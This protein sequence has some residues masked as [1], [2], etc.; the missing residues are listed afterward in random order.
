MAFSEKYKK[1]AEE[2]QLLCFEIGWCSKMRNKTS[3]FGFPVL[4]VS[5]MNE[6]KKYYTMKFNNIINHTGKVWC[7]TTK[8]R[9]WVAYR[10]GTMFITGNSSWKQEMGNEKFNEQVTWEL[11]CLEKSDV[12]VMYIDKDSKSPISLL[13]LGLFKDKKMLVYCPD[14][15]YRSGNIQIVCARYKVPLF[16]DKKEFI[17]VL[18]K[19]IKTS[20][21]ELFEHIR[22]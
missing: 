22:G 3:G 1:F 8:N 16:K 2:F 12:I 19:E 15:F 18:K 10:N 6:N 11:D 17:E 13:E 5:L 9:S 14:G 4:N 21:Q 7:P 20:E